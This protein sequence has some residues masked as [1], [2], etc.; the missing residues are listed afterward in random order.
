MN[1]RTLL[2]WCISLVLTLTGSLLAT[3]TELVELARSSK[4]S[5][6]RLLIR[7][8]RGREV[9][10]GTGF[11]IHASG[12]LVTNFHVVE[13]AKEVEAEMTDGRKI[14]ILGFLAEDQANDIAI[15][16]AD[17]RP[18]PSEILA[19][20]E[21]AKDGVES[22]ERVFLVGAPRGLVGTLSEGIVSAIRRTEDL[23]KFDPDQHKGRDP[24][25]QITAAISPGSSGSP[26]INTQGQAVGVAVSFLG[27]GQS[28]NFCRAC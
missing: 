18:A 15:L 11:F 5:V 23:D 7:D 6:V 28:L 22:G 12:R 1:R 26:V 9:G 3:A 14:P 21:A 2:F 17:F 10:T 8:D 13:H 24:L 16:K 19:L 27:G 20:A 4:P 25:L